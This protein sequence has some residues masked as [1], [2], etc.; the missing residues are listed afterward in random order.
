MMKGSI[1]AFNFRNFK[2]KKILGSPFWQLEFCCCSVGIITEEMV[3]KH[4][5]FHRNSNE[6]NNENFILEDEQSRSRKL[7][8]ATV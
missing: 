6:N 3:N 4:I 8:L 5:D 2:I 1:Y 7:S